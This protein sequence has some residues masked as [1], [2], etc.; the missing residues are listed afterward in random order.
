MRAASSR[1]EVKVSLDPVEVQVG[2]SGWG[3]ATIRIDIPEGMHINS[4]NPPARWLEPTNVLADGCDLQV[5]WPRASEDR[6][7]GKVTLPLRLKSDRLPAEFE[8]TV[9]YQACTNTECLPKT[10][11]RL[12]GVL[13]G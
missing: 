12:H 4:A 3:L 11:V 13:V 9:R 6:Y 7:E 1:P 2:A 8:L 5:E 10:E